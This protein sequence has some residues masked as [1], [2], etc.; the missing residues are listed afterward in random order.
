MS[1]LLALA[2]IPAAILTAVLVGVLLAVSSTCDDDLAALNARLRDAETN[3]DSLNAELALLA[4]NTPT[5][6]SANVTDSDTGFISD[7]RG[8]A[9]SGFTI[10]AVASACLGDIDSAVLFNADTQASIPL[11]CTK[12]TVAGAGLEAAICT[13]PP[14]QP[15]GLFDITLQHS[16]TGA[17]GVRRVSCGTCYGALESAGVCESDALTFSSTTVTVDTSKITQCDGGIG[18]ITIETNDG[19]VVCQNLTN[20]PAADEATCLLP[21]SITSYTQAIV[22]ALGKPMHD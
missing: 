3:R 12:T 20:V 9:S 19:A 22:T 6:V 11:S 4:D 10:T 14:E 2:V 8:S 5:C 15:L 1:L 17:A 18:N 7:T 13:V 21:D 16:V